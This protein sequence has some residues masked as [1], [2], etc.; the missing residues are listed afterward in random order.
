MRLL[1]SALNNA[2]QLIAHLFKTFVGTLS[3]SSIIHWDGRISGASNKNQVIVGAQK[4]IRTREKGTAK[5]EAD[6]K[7]R[8]VQK[9]TLKSNLCEDVC[10]ML[11]HDDGRREVSCLW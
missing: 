7:S 8:L 9:T 5:L 4:K 3:S 11:R 10:G 6:A 2:A 1:S